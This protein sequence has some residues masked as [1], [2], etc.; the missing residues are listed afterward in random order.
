[1]PS[2]N[3]NS[4][5]GDGQIDANYGGGQWMDFVNVISGTSLGTASV[6]LKIDAHAT[7]NSYFS[8]SFLYFETSDE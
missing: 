6:D 7:S 8:R 4:L 1:M 3:V 2:V 5:A